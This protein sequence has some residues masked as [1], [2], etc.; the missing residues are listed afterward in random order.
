MKPQILYIILTLVN[1]LLN[2]HYHGEPK[3]GNHNFFIDLLG[4]A[5][6]YA[7]LIWGGFFDVFLK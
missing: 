3:E 7:L 5:I 2:A 4:I 1:L 6:T